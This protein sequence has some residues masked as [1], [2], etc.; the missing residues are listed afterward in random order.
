MIAGWCNGS[1]PDFGSG[2]S[3]FESRAG[4]FFG[5][6]QVDEVEGLLDQKV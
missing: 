5:G 4:S 2:C 1:T 6:K 3:W